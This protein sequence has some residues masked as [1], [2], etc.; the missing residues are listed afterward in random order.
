[1]LQS[2]QNKILISIK[3]IENSVQNSS[4]GKTE[5]LVMLK[6]KTFIQQYSNDSNLVSKNNLYT[7]K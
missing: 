1:M 7:G 2:L 3:I 4:E 6:D 5:G